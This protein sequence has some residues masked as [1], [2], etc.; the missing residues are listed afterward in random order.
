[1]VEARKATAVNP[2]HGTP[3]LLRGGTVIGSYAEGNGVQERSLDY[4]GGK[5]LTE[6]ILAL[7]ADADMSARFEHYLRSPK[8]MGEQFDFGAAEFAPWV[9]GATM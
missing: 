3:L 4:D 8:V 5:F 7:P 6:M 9:L 1:M 2:A